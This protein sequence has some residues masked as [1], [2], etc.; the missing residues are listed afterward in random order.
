M[1]SK[2]QKLFLFLT[3]AILLG[4][5]C[6]ILS[7]PVFLS[8]VNDGTAESSQSYDVSTAASLT[9][10]T[11]ASTVSS[12]T[13]IL[14][15]TTISPCEGIICLNNGTCSYD[16]VNQQAVCICTEPYFG[17]RCEK[18]RCNEHI[19]QNRGECS[20]DEG[21]QMAKCSCVD[22]YTGEFCEKHVCDEIDCQNGGT[23]YVESGAA[24]CKCEI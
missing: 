23:C 3:L 14:T 8:K 22:P 21:L 13:T 11:R 4:A 7:V 1:L 6:S 18:H 9:A 20:F 24:K 2:S 17:E 5:L 12:T 19:C 10:T 15:T 16:D